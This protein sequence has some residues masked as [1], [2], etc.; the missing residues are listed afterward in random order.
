MIQI[1]SPLHRA[2]EKGFLAVVKILVC[3]GADINLRISD[4]Q[5]LFGDAP[6]HRA[7]KEGQLECVKFLVEVGASIDI[8]NDDFNTPLHIAAYCGHVNV[9]EFLLFFFL[10][11]KHLDDAHTGNTLLQKGVQCAYLG[12][13]FLE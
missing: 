8:V 6:I 11:I 13:F 9:V 4:H 12:S 3:A 7:A 10:H 2:C 1:E 5:L